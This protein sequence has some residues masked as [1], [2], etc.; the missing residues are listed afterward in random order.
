MLIVADKCWLQSAATAE[1]RALKSQYRLILPDTFY[2]ELLTDEN[3]GNRALLARKFGPEENP[4]ARVFL[5]ELMSWEIERREPAHP[6][7]QFLKDNFRL[8]TG[9]R[10]SAFAFREDDVR[11]MARWERK[12]A[13]AVEQF[14]AQAAPIAH[15]FPE[16]KN[17]PPS[18]P[19][20]VIEEAMAKVGNTQTVLGIYERF[21]TDR[22]PPTELL[23]GK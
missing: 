22:L 13:A 1:K 10:T 3:R 18:G 16:L 20:A 8:N 9:L 21:R 23:D 4:G 19:R 15:W 17:F 6:M 5:P 7:D 12:N 2:L 11:H 14:K